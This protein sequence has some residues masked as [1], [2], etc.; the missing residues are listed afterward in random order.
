MSL[1][2]LFAVS[3]FVVPQI[4][5]DPGNGSNVILTIALTAIAIFLVIISVVVKR[6][7]LVQ[8]V[9][10]QDVRLVQQ[11]LIIA[12]AMCEACAILGLVQHFVT[13]NREYYFLF[14]LAAV[15]FMLHFPRRHHL[16]AASPRISIEG[17][18]S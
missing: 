11:A 7:L 8:S 16:V 3:R 6:K 17:A 4:S 15:G 18:N 9:E 5:S 12:F 2:L 14:L 1:G 10:K 13:G